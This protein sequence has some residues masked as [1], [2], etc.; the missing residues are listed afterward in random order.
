[1]DV[2]DSK[3]TPLGANRSLTQQK[4]RGLNDSIVPLTGTMTAAASLRAASVTRQIA[5]VNFDFDCLFCRIRTIPMGGTH[6]IFKLDG[7]TSIDVR[8]GRC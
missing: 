8:V 2:L 6:K 7:S 3:I 1:M 5:E 4:S